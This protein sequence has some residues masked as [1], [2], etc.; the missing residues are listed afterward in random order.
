MSD[1]AAA[2]NSA[3]GVAPAAPVAVSAPLK[4]LTQPQDKWAAGRLHYD[5]HRGVTFLVREFGAISFGIECRRYGAWSSFFTDFEIEQENAKA[6]F[7]ARIEAVHRAI[8]RYLDDRPVWTGL[9][10]ARGKTI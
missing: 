1:Y 8:E 2:I 6:D 4:R 3:L 9:W 5:H 7:N 10:Y